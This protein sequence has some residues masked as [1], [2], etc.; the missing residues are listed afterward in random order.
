M[1]V[2]KEILVATDFGDAANTAL[3]YA[4]ALARQ[5][6]GRLHVLHVVGNVMTTA[7]GV[8]GFAAMYPEMQRDI[9]DAARRQMDAIITDDDRAT[10]QVTTAIRESASPAAA[11]VEYARHR[12]I[13]LIVMG[14]HGRGPM[15]HLVMGSVAERVV[16]TAPCPVLTVRSP[17]HEFLQPDALVAVGK[18]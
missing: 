8:E 3:D 7:V 18:V 4:R 9:E 11:V 17:E 2:L 12:G 14:T 13:D 6:G 15:A 5:F 10:L 1:I 16:R